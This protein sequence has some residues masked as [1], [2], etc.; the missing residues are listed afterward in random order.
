MTIGTMMIT[1]RGDSSISIKTF[2]VQREGRPYGRYIFFD[3][4]HPKAIIK[5][6]VA[7]KTIAAPEAM[8]R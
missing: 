4:F 7:V 3:R 5:K 8:L 1:R 2:V 6:T